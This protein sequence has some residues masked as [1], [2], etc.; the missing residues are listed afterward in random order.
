MEFFEQDESDHETLQV[1]FSPVHFCDFSQNMEAF[2]PF[3]CISI[4]NQRENRDHG[5]L[6]VH[7]SPIHFCDFSICLEK[8]KVFA[9]LSLHFDHKFTKNSRSWDATGRPWSRS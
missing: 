9:P 5:T 2:A 8:M 6:Q 1:H 7:F 4:R 3:S